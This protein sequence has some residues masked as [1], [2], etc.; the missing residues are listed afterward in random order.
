MYRRML[1]VIGL[2]TALSASAMARQP[3]WQLLG[4]K[5]VG[6]LVDRDVINVGQTADWYANRAFKALHFQVERNDVHFDT[7]E[8]VYLNGYAE[9]INVDRLVRA[10]EE[11]P[12]DL[13]G[14]R[15]YIKQI[16]MRYRSRPNFRG[17]AVVRVMAEP[18]R[19]GSVPPPPAPPPSAGP[20]WEVLGE[21]TVGFEVDRDVIRVG[22]REGRF[23]RIR[24]EVRNN[25]VFVNNIRVR[26]GNGE[27][28]SFDLREEI[29]AGSRSRPLDLSGDRRFIERIELTYRARPGFRGQATVTVLGYQGPGRTSD[30]EVRRES[31]DRYPAW[32][33][34]WSKEIEDTQNRLT[35]KIEDGRREGSIDRREHDRLQGEMERI[36]KMVR[37][38]IANGNI[39]P[40]EMRSIREA[41]RSTEQQI[42]QARRD[43]R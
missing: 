8:L 24:L 37:R 38:V 1:A 27:E 12:I 17:Q 43:R 3:D 29:R 28:Q 20:D 42:N 11:V 15:S 9:T 19:R 39:T 10:G 33:R 2:I 22:R 30:R 26:F 18:A 14:E 5:S 4:E 34:V 31:E 40:D 16:G 25:D 41:Q 7:I 36:E 21:Q 6:F 32:T 13:R 23:S 35:T